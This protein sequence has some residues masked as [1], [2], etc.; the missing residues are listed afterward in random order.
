MGVPAG[1]NMRIAAPEGADGLCS[2]PRGDGEDRP[3]READRALPRVVAQR[4]EQ[5]AVE[6]EEELVGVLVDVPDVLALDL[7]DA[8]VV[9]VDP[10]DDAGAPQGVEGGQGL[11]EDDGSVAHESIV[12][13]SARSA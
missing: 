2:V 5:L 3:L 11:A 8:D 7:R 4:E 10:R 1:S 13:R 12:D 9:V 6:D